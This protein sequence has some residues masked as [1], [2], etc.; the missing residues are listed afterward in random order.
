MSDH[1]IQAEE[2]RDLSAPA[3]RGSR[4]YLTLSQACRYLGVSDTTLRDWTDAGKIKAFI[5]PGGHRRYTEAD[6][7]DFVESQP[8]VK[9]LADLIQQLKTVRV[10]YHLLTQEYAQTRLWYTKLDEAARSSLRDHCRLL[11]DLILAHLTDPRRRK[12]SASTARELGHRLGTEL[13]RLE[14]TLTDAIEAF[15]LYR[16]P[17]LD[18]VAEL[19]KSNE[20]V[21][22][23]VVRGIQAINAIIDSVLLGIVAYYQT[24][25][26]TPESALTLEYEL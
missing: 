25:N 12:E 18:T 24:Q 19:L 17:T 10:E 14:F 20:P 3:P 9:R 16:N 7:A 26:V 5:T 2:K 11:L 21:D 6:L 4:R 8:H 13:L 22:R 15:I 23:S 1:V